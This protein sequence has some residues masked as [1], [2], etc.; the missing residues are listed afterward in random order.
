ADDEECADRLA[1]TPFASDLRGQINHGPER[2]EGHLR[3]QLT[4]VAGGKPFQMLSQVDDAEALNRFGP[5][6]LGGNP[7]VK[8]YDVSAGL[9]LLIGNSFEEC[10][11][12]SFL[13]RTGVGFEIKDGDV[14][15]TLQTLRQRRIG[16][17]YKEPATRKAF[18]DDVPVEMRFD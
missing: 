12:D 15:D 7:V 8:Q 9:Q 14:L 17:R 5:P 6:L 18:A 2:F 10:Q 16:R 1:L 13:D 11:A 3:F 4:Q